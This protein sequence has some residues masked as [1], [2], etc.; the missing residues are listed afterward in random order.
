[1]DVIDTINQTVNYGSIILALEKSLITAQELLNWLCDANV[2]TSTY[3]VYRALCNFLCPNEQ[4]LTTGQHFLTVQ[5][6]YI[7]I[8]YDNGLSEQCKINRDEPNITIIDTYG[9]I[10]VEQLDDPDTHSLMELLNGE[11]DDVDYVVNHARFAL[12]CGLIPNVDMEDKHRQALMVETDSFEEIISEPYVPE[13]IITRLRRLR[14]LAPRY[15]PIVM[16]GYRQI[17]TD[18]YHNDNLYHL[19]Q[20]A[21]SELNDLMTDVID[22]PLLTLSTP[23]Y[24]L[25]GYR[26]VIVAYILGFPVNIHIPTMKQLVT[27]LSKL[28][29]IGIDTYYERIHE[30]NKSQLRT[31]SPWESQPIETINHLDHVSLE[32]IQEYSVVD[33]VR[34]RDGD[35]LFLFT[36]N[37]FLDM[38]KNKRN[39]WTNNELKPNVIVEMHNHITFA[40]HFRLPECQ[41]LKELARD[42]LTDDDY[43]LDVV[44]HD[45]IWNSVTIGGLAALFHLLRE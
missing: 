27:A 2:N 22:T 19:S 32:S 12:I 38:L 11:I 14:Q 7:T 25:F 37:T 3:V 21:L 20:T 28:D 10:I 43:E 8:A 30:Y 36:R 15:L 4:F 44:S 6:N 31:I 39:P 26:R 29:V 33:V 41:P 40:Y 9:D 1:M 42:I 45:E 16:D 23:T 18:F 5:P 34:Y 24:R 13:L 35:H 17:L